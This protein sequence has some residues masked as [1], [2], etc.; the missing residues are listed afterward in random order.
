[1][2]EHS[3]G[4]EG[5]SGRDTRHNSNRISFGEFDLSIMLVFSSRWI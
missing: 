3:F 4:R 2:G 5:P 1:M